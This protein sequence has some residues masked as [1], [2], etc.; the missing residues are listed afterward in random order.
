MSLPLE[1]GAE[2]NSGK[3]PGAKKAPCVSYLLPFMLLADSKGA[4]A[5]DVWENSEGSGMWNPR[6]VRAFSN[7]EL[8][9]VQS[10]I[11]PINNKKT[12]QLEEDRLLW[13]GD[14][15]GIFSVKA[16][17]ALL[18]GRSVRIVPMNLL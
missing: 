17:F 13:K 7:W 3:T 6:F 4:M 10:F 16:D 14:K 15:N 5:A 12:N 9:A 18:E 1:M 11:N 8:D 2:L